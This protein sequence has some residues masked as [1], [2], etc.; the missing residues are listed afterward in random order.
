MFWAWALNFTFRFPFFLQMRIL[1]I[2]RPNCTLSAFSWGLY[3]L[4]CKTI[5][6]WYINILVGMLCYVPV[7]QCITLWM[8]SIDPGFFDSLESYVL[9]ILYIC[10]LFFQLWI[11]KTASEPISS[12]CPCH[13]NSKLPLS[14]TIM[15]FSRAGN[16]EVDNDANKNSNYN[17]YPFRNTCGN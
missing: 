17:V 1:H 4:R 14:I 15:I 13:Y 9:C 10:L 8:K 6:Y 5:I 16:Y 11:S 12:W 2:F 7:F 3:F